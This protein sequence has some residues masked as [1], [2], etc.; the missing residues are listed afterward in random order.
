MPSRWPGIHTRKGVTRSWLSRSSRRSRLHDFIR[1]QGVHSC[2]PS[3]QVLFCGCLRS[4]GDQYDFT[5]QVAKA[6]D[7]RIFLKLM[8]GRRFTEWHDFADLWFPA[9]EFV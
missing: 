5:V 1:S 8:G 7:G 9:I 3:G 4:F 2:F 6:L